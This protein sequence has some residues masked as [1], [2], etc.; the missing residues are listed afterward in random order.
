MKYVKLA[1]SS[2]NARRNRNDFRYAFRYWTRWAFSFA[3]GT[4]NV[5]EI[6]FKMNPLL[7]SEEVRRLFR[8]QHEHQWS[9]DIMSCISANILDGMYAPC[10]KGDKFYRVCTRTFEVAYGNPYAPDEYHPGEIILP[11][12]HQKPKH[13]HQ[14]KCECGEEIL[15]PIKKEMK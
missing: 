8:C 2:K 13:E 14:F 9:C 7:Q 12:W 6:I 4:H 15:H 10:R 1:P 11:D 3:M 5:Y